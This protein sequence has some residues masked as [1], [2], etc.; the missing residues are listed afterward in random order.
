MNILHEANLFKYLKI[1]NLDAGNQ[2]GC[3][4]NL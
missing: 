4:L 3:P 1:S 2:G